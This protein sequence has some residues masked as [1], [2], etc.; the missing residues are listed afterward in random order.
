MISRLDP[1]DGTYEWQDGSTDFNY[2]I[3]E[4]GLYHVTLD[5]RCHLSSD[6]VN[7][8]VVEPPEP[9][10]WDLTPSCVQAI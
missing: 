1:G 10:R 8:T 7:V 9:C 6:T 3:S 2:T 5:N 4:T